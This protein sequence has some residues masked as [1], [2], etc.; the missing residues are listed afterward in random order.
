MHPGSRALKNI[1]EPAEAHRGGLTCCRKDQ[2]PELADHGRHITLNLDPFRNRLRYA[3][4]SSVVGLIFWLILKK[5]SGSYFR[6]TSTR[7][8]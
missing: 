1:E 7:R 2:L 3:A 5:F 6:F 8:W 4:L